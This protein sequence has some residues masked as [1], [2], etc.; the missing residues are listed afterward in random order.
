MKWN[1]KWSQWTK[2]LSK[3]S[4]TWVTATSVTSCRMNLWTNWQIFSCQEYNI[5]RLSLEKTR[6]AT[7]Y[8][9]RQC[10]SLHL[11]SGG[12][13]D[14]TLE[15]TYKWS[16]F[17]NQT[18]A[19]FVCGADLPHCCLS[20]LVATKSYSDIWIRWSYSQFDS[21]FMWGFLLTG[22]LPSWPWC[23]MG[24]HHWLGCC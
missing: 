13:E 19:T 12:K 20:S 5:L 24:W 23:K 22:Y 8:K 9:T 6:P 11:P 15:A 4:S 21:V 17:E 1:K 16:L 14:R 18:H 7:V 3:Q 2:T 10:S